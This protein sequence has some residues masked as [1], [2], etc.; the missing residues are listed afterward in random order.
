MFTFAIALGLTMLFAAASG[1][2]TPRARVAIRG[3]DDAVEL[4]RGRRLLVVN[5]DIRPH[6][7]IGPDGT[8]VRLERPGAACVLRFDRRGT[9]TVHAYGGPCLVPGLAVPARNATL[10]ITVR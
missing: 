10:S 1:V 2:R 3:T 7:L 8:V 9:Y 6:R 5:G 4:R